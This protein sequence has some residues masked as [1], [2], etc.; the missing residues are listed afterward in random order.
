[1]LDESSSSPLY[2]QLADLIRLKIQSGEYSLGMRLEPETDMAAS[3][4]VSRGTLRMALE[5]LKQEGLIDRSRGKGTFIASATNL[6]DENR[7]GLVVPYLN[8]NLTIGI[9]HGAES[10][11][12]RNG[13]NLIYSPSEN[14]IEVEIAQIRQLVQQKVSGLILMPTSLPD[15]GHMLAKILPP[16]IQL[17]I[18]DRTLPGWSVS[19]VMVNNRKGSG[20]LT[21]HLLDQGY[22]RITYLIEQFNVSA[23]RERE[24][25]HQEAM[26]QA[27]LVPYASIPVELNLIHWDGTPPSYSDDQMRDVMRFIEASSEPVG[28]VCVNDFVAIGVMNYLTAKGLRF[29]ED[30]GLAGF[31]DIPMASYLPIPLTTM[32]QPRLEIGKEAASLL[33]RQIHSP[34]IEPEHIELPVEFRPRA[35]TRRMVPL[36]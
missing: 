32:S 5:V 27:G 23:S 17:V 6:S 19:S 21:R 36:P 8:D 11:L 20:D 14:Q 28:F 7:V 4:G 16:D 10:V 3:Y 13:I 24:A 25:G 2:A 33:L 29:P 35:S 26:R 18:V 9:M 31:D 1:M 34:G 15:E 30:V 12:R 22:R